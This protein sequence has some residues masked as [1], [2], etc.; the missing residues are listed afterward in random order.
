M[1]EDQKVGFPLLVIWFSA[2]KWKSICFCSPAG[3]Q[4]KGEENE[5]EKSSRSEKGSKKS[6]KSKEHVAEDDTMGSPAEDRH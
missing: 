1:K 5:S 4:A 2:M 6:D 3:K